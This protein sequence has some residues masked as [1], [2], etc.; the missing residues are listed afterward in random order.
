[1]PWSMEILKNRIAYVSIQALRPTIG[2]T[3]V[4]VYRVAN[5]VSQ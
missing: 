2:P 4:K 3:M 5:K 1:M